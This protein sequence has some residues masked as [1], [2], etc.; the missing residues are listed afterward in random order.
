LDL[1]FASGQQ[2]RINTVYD[3][4]NSDRKM[5][6]GGRQKRRF[7]G[8][9]VE[10]KVRPIFSDSAAFDYSPYQ[11]QC[12]IVFVDGAHS[13]AYVESDTKAAFALARPGGL[14]VWHDYNNGFFWPDV[15]EYLNRIGRQYGIKR[16][17][18][19]MF[20]VARAA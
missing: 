17:R 20:A 16:I 7:L 12:D 5:I 2:D 10:S 9:P 14:V 6:F 8:S 4:S 19:T 18:G 13:L 15:H 3:V 1:P 11:K